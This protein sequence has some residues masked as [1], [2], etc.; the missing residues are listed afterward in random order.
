MPEDQTSPP[1]KV[2]THDKRVWLGVKPANLYKLLGT[3]VV[4]WLGG[5]KDLVLQ[6]KREAQ[7]ASKA[8]MEAVEATVETLSKKVDKLSDRVAFLSGRM[9]GGEYSPNGGGSK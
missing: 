5:G 6:P 1:F 8:D 4:L 2:E 9:G 7:T 3:L